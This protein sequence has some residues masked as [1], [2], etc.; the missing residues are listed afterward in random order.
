MLVSLVNIRN[1]LYTILYPRVCFG[2]NA[3]LVLNERFLCT[4]C[5]YELPVTEYHLVV[6]NPVEKIFLGRIPIER[7][8]S[9][10]RFEKK[11]MVQ[12][13][14]FYWKYRNQPK[15]GRF[16]GQMIGATLNASACYADVDVVIPVPMHPKKQR[17]RGYNQVDSFAEEIAVA[18][19]IPLL[20]EVLVKTSNT[21]SQTK[22]SRWKRSEKLVNVYKLKKPEL[23]RGKHILLI[24]DLIT[25]GGTME[26]CG[27]VLLENTNSK[28]SLLSFAVTA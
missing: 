3:H 2:C 21:K 14:L 5:R 12:Q 22:K 20:K 27:V 18:L 17:K 6:G 15:L 10:L 4:F 9:F 26:A 11:G 24:D 28:L 1:D 25:T 7:A 13:I 19:K 16:F 8:S 23:V